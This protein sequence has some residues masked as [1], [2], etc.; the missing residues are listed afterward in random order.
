MTLLGHI[1]SFLNKFNEAEALL[2]PSL[3]LRRKILGNEH[4]LTINSMCI[5]ARTYVQQGKFAEAKE[6]TDE[7]KSLG[8][9]LKI[10]DGLF[11]Q[12]N[13]SVLGWCYLEQGHFAE[14]GTLC[15][16]AVQATERKPDGNPLANANTFIHLG[17]VRLAQERYADA[18]KLLTEGLPFVEKYWANE[19]YRPYVMS[20]LGASLSGQKRYDDAE[21]LLLQGYEGLVQ[22]QASLPPV[23]QRPAPDHGIPRTAGPT[24]RCLE[25]TG[26]GRRVETETGRVPAGQQNGREERGAAVN[27]NREEALL[28]LALE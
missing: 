16:L 23:S 25:Q 3:E 21:P 12:W 4:S 10:E 20:L 22:R 14:A 2:L 15:K 1:Y 8:L 5:L 27:P 19:A 24:L 11:T 6:L 9:R 7:L 28:L 17:A 13:V 18:E 26:P